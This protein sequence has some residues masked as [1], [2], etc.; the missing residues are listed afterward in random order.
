MI[1]RVILCTFSLRKGMIDGPASTSRRASKGYRQAR[2]AHLDSANLVNN[3]EMEKIVTLEPAR[4]D[5]R[6]VSGRHYRSHLKEKQAVSF[7]NEK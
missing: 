2:L 4:S 1:V 6:S 7:L 5:T 3:F